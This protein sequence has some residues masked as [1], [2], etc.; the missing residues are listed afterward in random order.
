ME[1]KEHKSRAHLVF[2]LDDQFYGV[3]TSAVTQIIRSVA[4]TLIPDGPPLLSGLLNLHGD[5][6]PVI[7]IRRQLKRVQKIMDTGDRIVVVSVNNLLA[8]FVCD[9]IKGIVAIDILTAKNAPKI[10]PDL[11]DVLSA[12]GRLNEKTVLIYDTKALFPADKIAEIH[13]RIKA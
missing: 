7:D 11:A 2:T 8:A 3:D 6:V 12:V 13:K 5:I 9:D 1:K 10:H 4:L